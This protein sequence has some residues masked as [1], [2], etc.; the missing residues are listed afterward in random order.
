[1]STLEWYPEV[2]PDGLWRPTS[3]DGQTINLGFET[4]RECRAYL[5]RSGLTPKGPLICFSEYVS[6]D[7][8]QRF[9]DAWK[10]RNNKTMV[11]P[12]PAPAKRCLKCEGDFIAQ[13]HPGGRAITARSLKEQ[14]EAGRPYP[15]SCHETNEF[16]DWRGEHIRTDRIDE[17]DDDRW[18]WV[19][20]STYGQP[21][22]IKGECNHKTPEPV[23]AYPSGELVAWLCVDCGDTFEADRWPVPEGM[24][25]RIPHL[26]EDGPSGSLHKT[27]GQPVIRQDDDLRTHWLFAGLGLLAKET[28]GMLELAWNRL[29]V[30]TNQAMIIS[31]VGS[32]WLIGHGLGWW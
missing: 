28:W 6:A 32:W 17:P 31:M 21:Q 1:M 12:D 25:R 11:L 30:R 29:K 7:Q 8:M 18:E 14:A 19:D 3:T 15:C 20:V 9:L 13:F 4:A 26:F 2:S 10:K 27:D 16:T 23:D 5:V 24:W 22:W